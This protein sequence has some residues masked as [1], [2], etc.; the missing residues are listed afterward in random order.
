MAP[1]FRPKKP[2]QTVERHFEVVAVETV[3]VVELSSIVFEAVAVAAVVVVEVVG[4]GDDAGGMPRDPCCRIESFLR[5]EEN[6][7][8]DKNLLR[9]ELKGRRRIVRAKIE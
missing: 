7:A 2:R 5:P 8:A 9:C 4:G 3:C 6:F 1:T